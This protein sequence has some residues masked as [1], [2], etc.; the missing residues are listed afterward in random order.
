MM[1][2]LKA[3]ETGWARLRDLL[4][5]RQTDLEVWGFS[6]SYLLKAV[7]HYSTIACLKSFRAFMHRFSSSTTMFETRMH[8]TI[9]IG[10]LISC[11]LTF[12]LYKFNNTTT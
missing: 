12:S 4:H 6:Q 10:L 5:L 8:L 11:C 9:L 3:Y 2:K 7:L 1:I